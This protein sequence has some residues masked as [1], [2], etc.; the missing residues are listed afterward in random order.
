MELETSNMMV[1]FFY[2][3]LL[4]WRC[5]SRFSKI[6]QFYSGS[7][8]LMCN[9]RLNGFYISR[10]NIRNKSFDVLVVIKNALLSFGYYWP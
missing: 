8:R 3:Y 4:F 2:D 6:R 10:I 1:G 5:F 9:I 7:W